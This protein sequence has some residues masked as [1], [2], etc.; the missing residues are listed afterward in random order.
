M[1]FTVIGGYVE[2]IEY[3]TKYNISR[4]RARQL[5]AGAKQKIRT[6]LTESAV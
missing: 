2:G 3:G 6:A 5:E 4:E 1:N